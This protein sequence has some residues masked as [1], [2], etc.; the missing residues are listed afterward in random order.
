MML[1]HRH[2]CLEKFIIS[3]LLYVLL[4]MAYSCANARLQPQANASNFKSK[5]SMT[6]HFKKSCN[7]HSGC[8]TA[9]TL[10]EGK[11]VF[12]LGN[13]ILPKVSISPNRHWIILS[14]GSPSVGRILK[15]YER[16]DTLPLSYHLNDNIDFDKYMNKVLIQENPLLMKH[17]W[18]WE[19]RYLHIVKWL[20]HSSKLKIRLQGKIVLFI[21][22]QE[23][24][25][26]PINIL[27]TL[28]LSQ[29]NNTMT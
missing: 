9:V 20:D 14:T 23:R 7:Q 12:L 6:Y 10:H 25:Q 24:L 11:H 4:L 1:N 16:Q 8:I 17:P 26:V 18:A 3:S 21:N 15:L 13:F 2:N 5:H 29:L 28:H 22:N 27:K 19:H